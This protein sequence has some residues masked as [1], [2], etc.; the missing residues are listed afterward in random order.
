MN[1]YHVYNR[2]RTTEVCCMRVFFLWP[3]YIGTCKCVQVYTCVYMHAQWACQ[4]PRVKMLYCILWLF[5]C[6]SLVKIQSS[7][8]PKSMLLWFFCRMEMA[9][10]KCTKQSHLIA[11]LL[12]CL[13]VYSPIYPSICLHTNWLIASLIHLLIKNVFLC[14][15]PCCINSPNHLLS[16]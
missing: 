4:H 10:L 6:C 5:T 13:L 8:Y 7:L 3:W 15:F 9:I 11:F 1:N 16:I 14:L 12:V 2:W